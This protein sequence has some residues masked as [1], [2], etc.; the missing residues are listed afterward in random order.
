MDFKLPELGENVTSGDVLRVLVQ[1]GDTLAAIAEKW[2]TTVEA[3][4]TANGIANPNL[5]G[6]GMRLAMPHGAAPRI[7]APSGGESYIVQSGDT[8]WGI[9]QRFGTSVEALMAANGL[10]DPG[11]LLVGQA[12][13]IP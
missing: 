9:A 8:L 12:L 6:A 10:S 5:I 11:L 1:P 13:T 2:G 7:E 4:A 3:L